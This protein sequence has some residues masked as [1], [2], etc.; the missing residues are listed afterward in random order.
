MVLRM[1][2]AFRKFNT[3]NQSGEYTEAFGRMES[4]FGRDRTAEAITLAIDCGGGWDA[5]EVPAISTI[6]GMIRQL[7]VPERT[8]CSKC[9]GLNG[10][11]YVDPTNTFKGMV[12][13][14]HDEAA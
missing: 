3:D 14:T 2:G 9:A 6:R 10:F 1:R 8:R 13:C 4:D 11:L 12:R 7:P 5:N